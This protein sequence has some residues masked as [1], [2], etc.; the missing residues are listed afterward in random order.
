MAAPNPFGNVQLDAFFM[1]APQMGLPAN[2]RRRLQNEGLVLISDFNEFKKDQLE[3]AFKNMRIPIPGIP[4]VVNDAGIELVPAVPPIPPCLVSARCAL[5]LNV[6]SLAYHYYINIDRTP[7]PANMNYTQVLKGFYTEWESIIKLSEEDRPKVPVLSKNQTP[8]RWMESFKDC[9]YRT[10]GVRTCPISYV[11]RSNVEVEDEAS[12][13]LDFG[14]CFGR[15]GSVLEELISRLNHTDPLYRTDNA[16]VYSLLDEAMRGTIYAPTIKPFARTKNGRD[17]WYAIIRSH[18]GD[19]KWEDVKK[20]KINFLMNTKWNGRTYSLDKFTGLHRSA[21]VML[22]EAALH[23]NFQVPSQHSRVGYLLDNITNNDPDLRAA[24]ASIRV[25][26]NGM[27]DN[28]ERAV[29]FMLPVCPYTKHKTNQRR[30]RHAS[31]SDVRLKGKSDSKTG[32]DLRWHTK[33][34]YSKLTKEQRAEL[35]QWQ[36]TK[37]GKEAM[38]KSRRNQN[39]KMTKKQLKAHIQ[40][41]ENKLES[42]RD[43]NMKETN[44][45]S[46]VPSVSEIQALISAT[47]PLPPVPSNTPIPKPTKRPDDRYQLAA[48]A[49]Q[50]ILKR[51]RKE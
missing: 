30:T 43:K 50:Q 13:P 11:I 23:V 29:A 18:A 16:L 26:T 42:E 34:E 2:V 35:Y 3:Q 41:L 32:V 24:L 27:R 20:E 45:E 10:Y 17:A 6:A 33:E 19:D 46:K 49:V 44:I 21:F 51:S 40:S 8:L 12:D 36:Q 48:A 37:N 47:A 39:K 25:N 22:E 28:F 4:P 7:T 38:D 5:R 15:S 31:I 14:N 9:L 1:N